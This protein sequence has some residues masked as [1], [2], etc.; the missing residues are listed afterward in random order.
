MSDQSW[1]TGGYDPKRYI[2]MKGDGTPVDPKGEYFTLRIDTDP[3]AR[4]A[5]ETY[6]NSVQTENPQLAVDLRNLLKQLP[7][8]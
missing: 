4:R 3:H 8:L 7:P 6:A 1:K 5:V 2:T